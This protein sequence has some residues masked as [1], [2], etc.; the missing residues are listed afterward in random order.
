MDRTW[1]VTLRQGHRASA[2]GSLRLKLHYRA[3]ASAADDSHDCQQTRRTRRRQEWTAETPGMPGGQFESANGARDD[4]AAES[5]QRRTS[6]KQK[7]D[8]GQYSDRQK[9]DTPQ[10]E[11]RHER[12]QHEAPEHRALSRTDGLPS[13]TEPATR[14]QDS[15]HAD[16]RGGAA[17]E[18]SG[19]CQFPS[20]VGTSVEEVCG[21]ESRRSA[22]AMELPSSNN[23]V[24]G[25]MPVV[26]Q[27]GKG[28]GGGKGYDQQA[29]VGGTSPNMMAELARMLQ[30]MAAGTGWQQQQQQQQPNQKGGSWSQGS[31]G[32][33][34]ESAAPSGGGFPG[35][36]GEA[37]LSAYERWAQE[38]EAEAKADTMEHAKRLMTE[39]R[40]AKDTRFGRVRFWFPQ[41][42]MTY[43]G[44]NPKLKGR[45]ETYG[46]LSVDWGGL[47][48]IGKFAEEDMLTAAHE[49]GSKEKTTCRVLAI[50]MEPEYA[51]AIAESEAVPVVLRVPNGYQDEL[52]E[53]LGRYSWDFM[54][55]RE[56][57]KTFEHILELGMNHMKNPKR[58]TSM[59]TILDRHSVASALDMKTRMAEQ[60]EREIQKRLAKEREAM[61][62]ELEAERKKAEEAQRRADETRNS[63]ALKRS[64]AAPM[65]WGA[66][67]DPEG[68]SGCSG[69]GDAESSTR[70]PG[71]ATASMA[72]T[73][74]SPDRR[75]LFSLPDSNTFPCD[76]DPMMTGTRAMDHRA[77]DGDM[78]DASMGIAGEPEAEQHTPDD[79]R[80]RHGQDDDA[81]NFVRRLQ[82]ALV[83]ERV[84]STHQFKHTDVPQG[85]PAKQAS[86][87]SAGR[88]EGG[89][90]P[91]RTCR[92]RGPCSPPRNVRVCQ[93]GKG[94]LD[95]WV[96][97]TTKSMDPAGAW[98]GLAKKQTGQKQT[99]P[100][101]TAQDKKH[102]T[103]A[104]VKK[105]ES[106]AGKKS[107]ATAP[108]EGADS[109]DERSDEL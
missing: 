89:S 90:K 3:T 82:Q 100:S 26:G 18:N 13:N 91:H 102:I 22:E 69:R 74:Y 72:T 65:R 64:P 84:E 34:S 2:K 15:P 38:K 109:G 6:D 48:S 73:P 52:Q 5:K 105:A 85:K 81:G 68:S 43:E 107:K 99:K 32:G 98:S 86:S 103:R 24:V 37:E 31:A 21:E 88:Q 83:E 92:K 50:A 27:K 57:R 19:V 10:R 70:T 108:D 95:G 76:L 16:E 7:R 78:S 96:K 17:C 28:K 25:R 42:A 35:G 75:Q 36:G 106:K 61:K 55:D 66:P 59:D 77:A 63:R 12:P 8:R 45:M 44:A 40:S 49:L 33:W 79:E 93:P 101:T 56:S 58:S 47:H 53:Q 41:S 1:T 46:Q 4:E 62:K 23:V 104:S 94:T 14:K 11:R 29:A 9:R 39:R 67:A 54:D 80:R 97:K 30:T 51:Y 60:M 87:D 71:S 20:S